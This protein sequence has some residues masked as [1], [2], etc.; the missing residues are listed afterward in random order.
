MAL[1]GKTTGW[2]SIP[3]A[4]SAAREGRPVT[5]TCGGAEHG[6]RGRR[7]SRCSQEV[8]MYRYEFSFSSTAEYV[9]GA[10]LV[11]AMVA[12]ILA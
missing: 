3:V 9:V 4:R 8:E 2:D 6:R 12:A 5:G 11:V 7:L 10:L 1:L